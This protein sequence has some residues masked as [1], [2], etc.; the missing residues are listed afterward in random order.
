[1]PN[2]SDELELKLVHIATQ[3][4]NELGPRFAFVLVVGP[5]D[6]STTVRSMG[7]VSR[8]LQATLIAH[9]HKSFASELDRAT[10]PVGPFCSHC[11]ARRVELSAVAAERLELGL[12][13]YCDVCKNAPLGVPFRP[14]CPHS[15]AAPSLCPTCSAPP[16]TKAE[17]VQALNDSD[18]SETVGQRLA[19]IRTA[20]VPP[21]SQARLAGLSGVDPTTISRIER[22]VVEADTSTLRRLAD[23]LQ[24]DIA[25]L[26]E[27]APSGVAELARQFREHLDKCETC[28]G[29][30][31]CETG[32]ALLAE[33]VP[34]P[35]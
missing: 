1:M 12:P 24:V 20:K 4:A 19:R 15:W 10:A 2:A 16:L 21:L 33:M 25:R 26:L 5:F 8:E 22:D 31:P 6:Q 34:G 29:L 30:E 32:A 11:R 3:I 17:I 13:I 28:M 23:A 14:G 9:V 27:P 18:G 35:G 7:N